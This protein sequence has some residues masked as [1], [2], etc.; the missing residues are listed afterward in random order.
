MP[1]G[2][3]ESRDG[4]SLQVALGR[5]LNPDQS[6]FPQTIK[7]QMD[8]AGTVCRWCVAVQRGVSSSR[9]QF[10][11]ARGS[12]LHGSE[13]ARLRVDLLQPGEGLEATQ[14]GPDH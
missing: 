8:S 1:L 4:V 3:A 7:N 10:R 14:V 2:V 9:L 6:S 13:E 12:R 5:T 11:R